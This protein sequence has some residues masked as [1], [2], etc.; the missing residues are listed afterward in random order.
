MAQNGQ[1]NMFRPMSPQDHVELLTSRF[2]IC[3]S[4]LQ[5]GRGC[6]V[7]LERSMLFCWWFPFGRR[8]ASWLRKRERQLTSHP[9]H[10]NRSELAQCQ[11][12]QYPIFPHCHIMP[13]WPLR[14]ASKCSPRFRF[15]SYLCATLFR[16]SAA[17]SGFVSLL[18]FML[19]LHALVLC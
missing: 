2:A 7:G 9:F 10:S 13:W 3:C 8:G 12:P 14:K 4:L 19:T 1:P 18:S 6:R 16:S 5:F 17:S 15:L 11:Q